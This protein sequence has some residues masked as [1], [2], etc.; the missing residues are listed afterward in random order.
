MDLGRCYLY[1]S[2]FI[3]SAKFCNGT[4]VTCDGL[5]QWGSQSL[6]Q[7][8]LTSL[9]ILRRYYGSNIELVVEAPMQDIRTSY[10]GAPLRVGSSGP[11]VVVVQTEL[12]RVGQNYPA[13]PK[14]SPVD[15]IFGSETENAVRRFQEIFGLTSDGVV[16]KTTWYRLVFL[17]GGILGLSE[18]VSQG[19]QF[20]GLAYRPLETAASGDSAEGVLVVQYFLSVLAQFESTIPMLTVDGV[21]GAQT[22]RAVRAF[23]TGQGLPATGRVNDATWNALFNAYEGIDVTVLS[24]EVLFPSELQ[25]MGN[26]PEVFELSTRLTQYPGRELGLGDRDVERRES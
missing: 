23:Q 25:G 11:D 1:C 17:Y 3:R 13:I 22:E 16:G 24:H 10:P 15:G 2:S 18:L 7:Q 26:D 19:Q 5:S 8:G 9:D 12:N 14:I 20:F 21:Y 6:A 4:T